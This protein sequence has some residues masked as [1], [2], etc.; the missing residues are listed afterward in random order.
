MGPSLLLTAVLAASG[1]PTIDWPPGGDFV[2]QEKWFGFGTNLMLLDADEQPFGV[3]EEKVLSVGVQMRVKNREG[4]LVLTAKERVLSW[5]R[6]Y[7][8][9]DCAGRL[10]A[11]LEERV[12]DSAFSLASTRYDLTLADGRR[13]DSTLRSW[14][15][16][17]LA[18]TENGS[19][20]A[21]VERPMFGLR[22]T[23]KGSAQ[24]ELAAVAAP[25]GGAED[26][27]GQRDERR[28]KG[29]TPDFL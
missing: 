20:V 3:I 12:L 27:G 14:L 5:G 4:Q 29:E 21:V 6:E 18:F 11:T 25:G 22:D 1:C 28:M 13:F 8:L 2:A 26:P 15:G 19:T 9:K 17:S 16:T 10:V 24:P 23:W 7:R